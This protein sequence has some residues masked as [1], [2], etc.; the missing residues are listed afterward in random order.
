MEKEPITINGLQNL[1]IELE[2]ADLWKYI[3]EPFLVVTEFK[4]I[5]DFK[6]TKKSQTKKKKVRYVKI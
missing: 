6:K 2:D 5:D 3:V 4:K 1:K